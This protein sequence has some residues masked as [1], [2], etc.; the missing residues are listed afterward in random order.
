MNRPIERLLATIL[1]LVL[2]SSAA[3]TALGEPA[4]PNI[5]FNSTETPTPQPAAS[6]TTAGGSFTTLLL[7]ATTQTMRWKAY[8]GNVTGNFKLQDA[9]NYSIYD[10]NI[11]TIGG[12]VYASRNSSISWADIRCAA[13]STLQT[14]QI[15]L[16]ITTTKED[17]INRTFGSTV[18]RGFYVGTRLISNS[19]CRAIATYVNNTKQTA[20]ESASFQEILLDDTQRLVYVTLLDGKKQGYNNGLFDF[21]LI[22]AESEYNAQ[23]SPYYFWVELS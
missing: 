5:I 3:F 21:Q 2:L 1:L 18:H 12:E 6:I 20:S 19:T 8:V 15:G 14:E 22:V 11:T 4:G 13:N 23:P 16:N 7:N 17:S 10:W 9:S